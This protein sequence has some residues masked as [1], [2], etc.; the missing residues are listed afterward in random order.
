MED[1]PSPSPD[2]SPI[3]DS[4]PQDSAPQDSAPQDPLPGDP[5][6]MPGRPP[7]R[8]Q[9]NRIVMADV[10]G[11]L[12]A[13]WADY[14]RGG[15]ASLSYGLIFVVVGYGLTIG[16]VQLDMAY[17]ISP[18]IGGFLLVGPI[19]GIGLCEI[20]R[21][22]ERGNPP[23]LPTALLAFRRN[24]FHIMTAGLVL[25]I[26]MMIWVRIAVLIFAIT[27]PYTSIS[28]HNMVTHAL[29]SLD[30]A[31]FLV[32]GT[33]V[34]AGFAV[35]AFVFGVISLP[36]M[37]DRKEDIFTAASVS[38]RTVRLNRRPLMGWAAII[39]LFIG[40]GLATAYVGLIVTMPLIGHA[41]W[42]AYR[43]MV[44]P[45]VEPEPATEP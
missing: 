4:P 32:L 24:G 22:L 10:F 8:F 37:L 9:V 14:R 26:F 20:S 7:P 29:T 13:G 19:L 35:L 3:P 44:T 23:S 15:V 42:H 34:G 11:W 6:D 36:L 17:L 33:A 1:T 41:T 39:V 43:S 18:M 38:L 27:F 5:S 16:L 30:G 25:M 45:L 2:P 12:A 28:W 21:T 31:I 40:G